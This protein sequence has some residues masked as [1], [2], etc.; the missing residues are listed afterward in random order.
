MKKSKTKSQP[1]TKNILIIIMAVLILIILVYSGVNLINNYQNNLEQKDTYFVI[2]IIDGDTFIIETGERVRLICVDTPEIGEKSYNE[3]IDRVV[4]NLLLK[5]QKSKVVS[6]HDKQIQKVRNLISMQRKQVVNMEKMSEESTKIGNKI[7]ENYQLLK[8]ILTQIN[9]AREKYS[10]K[11][12]KEK[13]KD[14][15]IIKE[16]N[17]KDKQIFIELK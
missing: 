1:E 11:D 4:T 9:K 17:T 15:A 7:Y 5:E 8:D 12:I 3:A 14:H 16:V 13:L 10:L 2:E 6:K